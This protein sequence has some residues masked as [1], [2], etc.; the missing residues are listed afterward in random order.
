MLTFSD[1][2]RLVIG[3]EQAPHGWAKMYDLPPQKVWDWLKNERTPQRAQVALLADKTGI[4]VDWWLHGEGPVPPHKPPAVPEEAPADGQ[5][6]VQEIVQSQVDYDQW[7]ESVRMAE[8]FV[9]VRYYRHARVSAGHGARN[10]DGRPDALLFSRSFLQTIG[11]KPAN[12]FLVRVV[13]DSMFPTLQAGW[14]VML[15]TSRTQVS[16][17]IYVVRF[18]GEELC[19]RLEARPGGI[20]KVISDNRLYEE[21]EI[22]A[23][24]A[25]ADFAVL[26]KVIWFAGLVQ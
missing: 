15:D 22:D 10:H 16:S 21:Y 24:K 2:L 7:A 23:T 4:A 5:I 3:E 17:G 26:G 6:Q 9:P 1:R 20:V 13:G 14:T 19:K 11:V 18:A 8:D 25:G 12:L